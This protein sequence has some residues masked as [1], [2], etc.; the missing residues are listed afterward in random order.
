MG[1]KQ[2]TAYL[3]PVLVRQEAA[4]FLEGSQ[5]L[6][7][8]AVLLQVPVQIAHQ[9]LAHLAEAT[10]LPWHHTDYTREPRLRGGEAPPHPGG[11]SQPQPPRSSP[12]AAGSPRLEQR[13]SML[14]TSSGLASS[15]R[16]DRMELP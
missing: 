3:L 14:H 12:V 5:D 9:L 13:W 7:L 11:A 2:P 10:V 8:G 15:R 16:I 1:R 4:A 6:L